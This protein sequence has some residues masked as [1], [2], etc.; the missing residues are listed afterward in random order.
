MLRNAFTG[1]SE[2][3][4][5]HMYERTVGDIGA[6]KG[7]VDAK[8]ILL[9]WDAIPP[10]Q[11]EQCPAHHMCGRYQ[12][13]GKCTVMLSYMKGIGTV[14]LREYKDVMTDED[15]I[16]IG[17]HLLPLY[18]NLCKL[19]IEELG[20]RR[21]LNTNMQGNY[22]VNPIYREIRDTIKTIET[23]WKNLALPAPMNGKGNGGSGG[24]K[25]PL[26][27][28]EIYGDPE[29]Y[30]SLGEFEPDRPKVLKRKK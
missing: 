28:P 6:R 5:N 4:I 10:C 12:H 3:P 16:K 26:R 15:L 18:R 23:V 21:V 9:T 22:V 20:V 13:K 14:L 29:Y 7:M 1:F 30:E 24:K 17:L 27:D 19:K 2:H 25:P 11:D 8:K